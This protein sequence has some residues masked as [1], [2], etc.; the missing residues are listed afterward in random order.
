M[1]TAPDRLVVRPDEGEA[2]ALGGLGVV[3]KVSG[4]QTGGAFA[5]VEHP[6]EPGTCT[7]AHAHARE[8]ELSFVIEG[9]LGARVG[10]RELS[11]GPGS[12]VWKPRGVPHAF[13][14]AGP[15]R[16][17]ILEIISPAGFERYFAELAA[18][19]ARGATREELRA[20]RDRYGLTVVDWADEL[21]RKYGVQVWRG[22]R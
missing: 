3:F 18:L 2:V 1:S 14:N 22:G 8:D 17:R 4:E 20:I 16:A 19:M 13:W 15:G 5:I 6:I 11:A 9:T 10:A 12:Y 7:V 21:A